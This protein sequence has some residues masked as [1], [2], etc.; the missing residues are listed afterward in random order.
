LQGTSGDWACGAR[1]HAVLRWSMNA[2][3]RMDE[4]VNQAIGNAVFTLRIFVGIQYPFHL[5]AVTTVSYQETVIVH[6]PV[7]SHSAPLY[8]LLQQYHT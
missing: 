5:L 4:K 6:H 3:R 1:R 2:L 8:W 7:P